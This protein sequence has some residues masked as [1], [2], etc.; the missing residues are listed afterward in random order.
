MRADYVKNRMLWH[1]SKQLIVPYTYWKHKGVFLQYS[2]WACG[3][4]ALVKMHKN[5][6][7]SSM[8]GFLGVLILRLVHNEPLVIYQ[9]QLKFFF[10]S[11]GS[12]AGFRSWV[13]AWWVL[14]LC[15]HLSILPTWDSRFS[16]WPYFSHRLR[17][18]VDFFSSCVQ[19]LLLLGLNDNF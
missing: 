8:A 9:L 16:L 10:P 5:V 18:V 7:G 3:R 4:I 13:S 12:P 15:I 6:G 19:L 1:I 11:T 2:L 17:K 14:I